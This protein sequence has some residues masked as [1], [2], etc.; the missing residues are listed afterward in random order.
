MF[1]LFD[2]RRQSRLLRYTRRRCGILHLCLVEPL[3]LCARIV[4][5]DVG[6]NDVLMTLGVDLYLNPLYICIYNLVSSQLDF[7]CR[8]FLSKLQSSSI[9]SQPIM[10]RASSINET[11][12]ES[13]TLLRGLCA[14]DE[15]VEDGIELVV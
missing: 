2:R 10:A 14:G 4:Y 1:Y 5:R 9:V 6:S 12:S 15:V 11:T 13:C 8:Y 3:M 7:H